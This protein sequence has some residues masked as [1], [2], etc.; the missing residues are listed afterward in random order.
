[1]A[2]ALPPTNLRIAA[3]GDVAN[4]KIK[5]CNVCSTNG[6]P[7][8]SIQFQKVPGRV[9]A[10]GTN[11]VKGWRVRDYFTGRAHT[12]KSKNKRPDGLV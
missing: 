5:S 12:H 6:W 8:E 4:D 10:D 1:M 11:E 7:H 2:T 9:L 3:A